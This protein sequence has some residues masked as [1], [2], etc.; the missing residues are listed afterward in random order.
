M[1]GKTVELTEGQLH[2]ADITLTLANGRKY[3]GRVEGDRM[4]APPQGPAAGAAA[5]WHAK[6]AS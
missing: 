5:S 6:R 2:G 1:P 3:Q 4:R